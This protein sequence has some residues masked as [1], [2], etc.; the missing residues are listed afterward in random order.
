MPKIKGIIT[1]QGTMNGMTFYETLDGPMV[2]SKSSIDKERIATDP[3]YERTRE[4]G[5]EFGHCSKM[6]KLLRNS[7]SSKVMYAKDYV[8][9]G[10][11]NRIMLQIK[12]YDSM[13]IRGERK[14]WN[15]LLHPG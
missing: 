4:N 12:N 10:R 14:V 11:L 2:K 1:L 13:S 8:T 7:V 9:S 5:K 6:S 3:R 15:G